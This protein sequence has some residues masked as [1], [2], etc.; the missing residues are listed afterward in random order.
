[1][2]S[3]FNALQRSIISKG[4]QPLIKDAPHLNPMDARWMAGPRQ[5]FQ[6]I[7]CAEVPPWRRIFV[8]IDVSSAAAEARTGWFWKRPQDPG[9]RK[10]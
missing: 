5:S 3:M 9:C 2:G 10:V 6:R 8:P 1:M 7:V 4:P